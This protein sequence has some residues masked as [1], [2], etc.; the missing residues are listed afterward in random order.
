MKSFI[1]FNVGDLKYAISLDMIHRIVVV[2][3]LTKKNDDDGICDGMFTFEDEVIT[4][5]SFRTLIGL[6][7]YDLLVQQMFVDLKQQHKAWLNA[8]EDAVYKGAPFSKTT[9]PHACHLGKW[10]DSFSS[11]DDNVMTILKS[12]SGHHKNLHK[13]A[14]D[15]LEKYDKDPQSARDWVDSHVNDIYNNTISFLDKMA[16][17]FSQISN[18]SQKLLIINNA[19]TK[20]GVKVDS[21]DGIVHVEESAIKTDS[22]LKSIKKHL[23]IEGVLEHNNQLSS[24][25]SKI[26]L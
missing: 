24:I 14:I 16:T 17:E 13:S 12:L 10:I 22:H 25:V 4:V 9:D 2:P 26:I 19:E 23:E 1:L 8:L 18:D 21:I 3:K 11:Y 15:V 20:F 5:A 6:E 7:N